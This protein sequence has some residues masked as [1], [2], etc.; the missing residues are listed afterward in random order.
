MEL[1]HLRTFCEVAR[2]QSFTRAARNLYCAQS[3]VTA[4]IQCLEKVLGVPLFVRR[5]RC[6]IELT[7]AGEVLRIRA[8]QI[9]AVVDETDR[10]IHAIREGAFPR[11]YA[12]RTP[13]PL[14]P[15][16]SAA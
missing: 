3:T 13:A 11:L 7:A 1:H 5:G 16:L 6:P 9:L 4:Q 12:D 15:A 14:L 10:E 2:E 8:E